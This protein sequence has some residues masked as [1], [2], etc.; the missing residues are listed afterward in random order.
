MTRGDVLVAVVVAI[1]RQHGSPSHNAGWR[2]ARGSR[3][4]LHGS[5]YT[6]ARLSG[7]LTCWPPR[8]GSRSTLVVTAL[9]ARGW[10]VAQ[11]LPRSELPLPPA[12]D[13]GMSQPGRIEADARAGSRR[14]DRSAANARRLRG[15]VGPFASSLTEAFATEEERT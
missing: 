7:C 11:G 2:G 12:S 14:S 10:P 5:C 4:I 15:V 3:S 13:P 9:P 8:V 6:E 1:L